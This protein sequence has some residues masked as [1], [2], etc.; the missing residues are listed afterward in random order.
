MP[1]RFTPLVFAVSVLLALGTMRASEP[2]TTTA[3][4]P[5]VAA[6]MLSS[7]DVLAAIDLDRP[8]LEAVRT[9]VQA[10]DEPAAIAALARY[11]RG[12]QAFYDSFQPMTPDMSQLTD[13]LVGNARPLLERTGPFAPAHWL[14]NGQFDVRCPVLRFAER[15][16]YWDNLGALYRVTRDERI[17]REWVVLLRSFLAQVPYGED[18]SFWRTMHVGIQIRSA[19]PIA[20]RSFLNSPAFTDADLFGLLK[21]TLERTRFLRQR[22]N[23]TSNQLTFEMA[24]L[25]TSGVM[26]PEF[27]EAEEWCRYA[28]DTALA[29]LQIGWLPDGMSIELSPGYGQFFTNYYTL[30]DLAKKLGRPD[31][32]KLAGL[33]RGSEPLFDLFLKVMTPDRLTPATNDNAPVA[34]PAF[35]AKARARFPDHPHFRWAASDGREGK[36][37]GYTSVVL[38]YAG[39]A[40]MRSGWE[41]DAHL[42]YFDFGP[43]GYR[44]VHQDKLAIAFW[45]YGRQILFDSGRGRYGESP[46]RM[47]N[48]AL[49][50][51]AHST[52][53]VD[54]RP[55]RR[56]WY[57][58]PHPRHRP[59]V[60]ADDC[61]WVS[62]PVSDHA[63]GVYAE[64]YGLPGE[65]S[66][67]PYEPGSNFTQGWSRPARHHRRV[68]FFKPDVF[69]VADTLVAL[70]DQSH[71][72][73]ARWQLASVRT[74]L[75]ADGFALTTIDP[76][77][78]NLEIVPLR[79]DGLV[80]KATSAQEQPELL[81]WNAADT[82]RPAT[83]LQHI[84]A[85][86]GTVE[87]ITLLLPLRHG[88]SSRLKSA[89]AL[90]DSSFELDLTDGRQLL[91]DVPPD[92][93]QRI[94]M[95]D[96]AIQ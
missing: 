51:F 82:P 88:E 58:N 76:N 17:A 20:F 73:D 55:Q 91:L 28:G 83:T 71:R 42:L 92:P 75:A 31:A 69:V 7:R 39:F 6:V 19:L 27:R 4:P 67:Y 41:R 40:A 77:E 13:Q 5:P 30:H 68:L 48:Y 24:G 90:S 64:D 47:Q 22:H 36:P 96:R 16:Y 62:T 54:Q 85:G 84:R 18:D 32:E 44:H 72:Y 8:G 1:R 74:Q 60:P 80:V 70:D 46:P 10:G 11:Y 95:L 86:R 21:A 12:R 45:A 57:E 78:P 38:P 33:I 14:P 15:L 9:A 2:D 26:Y 87:F 56:P 53:I 94:T 50:T 81:G 37:P 63:A 34:V 79:T 3:S 23:L 66:A 52:V 89:R 59:Y 25:Y 43:V 93:T 61:G 35:L 49:D 29:D 65:S